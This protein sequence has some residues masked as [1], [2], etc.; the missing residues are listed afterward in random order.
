MIN[1]KIFEERIKTADSIIL[2]LINERKILTKLSEMEK[3]RFTQFY[4]KQANL[5][6]LAADLLYTISTEKAAKDFHKLN[7]DYECFLWV[8]NPSYYSMFYAVHAL[9]AYKGVR[10]LSSQGIHKITAHALIYFCLKNN[11][12]AKELYELF[13]QSQQE[14]AELLNLDEFKEKAKDL[15]ANY[16]YE[17]EKRSRFTYETG[18]EAKQN[19]AK[20]SLQRSKEF[21]HEIEKIIEKV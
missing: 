13:V 1:Q 16:F 12:I 2:E 10:L 9:L 21:L 4:Q 15:A 5:S 11:F 20:T 7:P 19:H 17:V 6:L 3:V 14:A 8:V 18:E